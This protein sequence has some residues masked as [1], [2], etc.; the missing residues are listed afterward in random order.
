MLD[1]CKSDDSDKEWQVSVYKWVNAKAYNMPVSVA[2]QMHRFRSDQEC[3]E[4]Q[5]K[6]DAVITYE[7]A[8]VSALVVT[9]FEDIGIVERQMNAALAVLGDK[10]PGKGDLA[11]YK[12]ALNSRIDFLTRQSY[13]SKLVRIIEDL[14]LRSIS[15]FAKKKVFELAKSD[16]AALPK[17]IKEEISDEFHLNMK[18]ICL[19]EQV[20]YLILKWKARGEIPSPNQLTEFMLYLFITTRCAPPSSQKVFDKIDPVLSESIA[21]THPLDFKAVCVSKSGVVHLQDVLV[22]FTHIKQPERVRFL[23]PEIY[24]LAAKRL[25]DLPILADEIESAQLTGLR[26]NGRGV[27][28]TCQ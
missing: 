27:C 21:P 18:S 4:A 7:K 16:W 28:G 17:P 26:L 5:E 6:I 11:T 10:P 20:C 1:N 13:A 19:L 3:K 2:D 15:V 8:S 25:L 12:E 9:Q 22:I 23:S 24:L 14:C